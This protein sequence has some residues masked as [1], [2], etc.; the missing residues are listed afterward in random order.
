MKHKKVTPDG[1]RSVEERIENVEK[2]TLNVS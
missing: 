2:G 1:Y